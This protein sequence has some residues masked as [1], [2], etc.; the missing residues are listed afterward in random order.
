MQCW[1][2]G[3]RRDGW[4]VLT[5]PVGFVLRRW[6]VTDLTVKA[7]GVVPGDPLDDRPL[8]LRLGAFGSASLLQGR[9]AGDL[10]EEIEEAFPEA[11]TGG[12]RALQFARSAPGMS[13]SL[14]G[15]SNVEHAKDNFALTGVPPASPDA[16]MGLF[17]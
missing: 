13:T 5:V 10:P 9:L 12:Q 1:L 8:E 7:G 4:A 3:S 17:E 2:V 6:D 16:V 14:V 15:V 11:S